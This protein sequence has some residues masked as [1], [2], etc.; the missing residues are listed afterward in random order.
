MNNTMGNLANK[1]TI[2]ADDVQLLFKCKINELENTKDKARSTLKSMQTWYSRN[3]LKL[4]AN[5]TQ[6]IIFG[7]NSNLGK[8]K[9]YNIL[10]DGS[11]FQIEEKVKNLGVWFDKNLNF[12]YHIDKMCS[13]MNG[14]LSYLNRIKNILDEKSRL[15]ITQSLVFSQINYCNLIWSKCSKDKLH[16]IQKTINFAAKTVTNGRYRKRDHVT[17]LLKNLNWLKIEQMI[18]LN[19]ATFVHKSTHNK[20]NSNTDQ[21]KFTLRSNIS[22]RSTRNDNHILSEYRRTNTG[23]KALSISGANIW[24]KLPRETREIE[25]VKAFKKHITSNYLELNKGE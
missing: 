18:N 9:D 20:N 1:T 22:N 19:Q 23:K 24:N 6:F 16:R 21:I 17:P 10:I 14:T 2:Y 15:L 5:K 11:K 8:V 25:S 12:D 3:G 13:R 7:S 4:N